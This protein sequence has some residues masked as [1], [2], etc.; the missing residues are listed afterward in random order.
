[1]RTLGML[2]SLII[3]SATMTRYLG[4]HGA[5]PEM[6]EPFLRGMRLDL[7]LFVAFNVLGLAEE[8]ALYE[9]ADVTVE[10][11]ENIS[12]MLQYSLKCTKQ[13]TT[14]QE[15]LRMVQAYLFLQERRFGD[16]I[17]FRL[18]VPEA[19]PRL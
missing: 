12:Y 10:I 5:G 8:A 13:D 9:N 11:I 3:V 19:C 7:R 6:A 17:H 16:R 14:F 18:S 1:M 4:T 2:I 15:E